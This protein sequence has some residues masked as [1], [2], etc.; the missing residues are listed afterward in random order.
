MELL[1]IEFPLFFCFSSQS[2]GFLISLSVHANDESLRV[3]VI[4]ESY[5]IRAESFVRCRLQTKSVIINVQA[6]GQYRNQIHVQF[7]SSV[8]AGS[9][10]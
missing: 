10:M 8:M 3:T 5:R 1:S 7:C 2:S 6:A 4:L 9:L